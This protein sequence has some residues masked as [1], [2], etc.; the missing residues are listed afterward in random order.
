MIF[1]YR[2]LNMMQLNTI[3]G[4]LNSGVGDLWNDLCI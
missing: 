2:M 3:L 1:T 4:R